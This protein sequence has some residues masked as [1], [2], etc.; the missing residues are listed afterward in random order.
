MTI[1]SRP[2][3]HLVL[4]RYPLLFNMED[5]QFWYERVDELAAQGLLAPDAVLNTLTQMIERDVLEGEPELLYLRKALHLHGTQENGARRLTQSA[6]LS[7]L[8][9]S[10]F[11]PPSTRCVGT[12]V[13][14]SLLY[15][16][17]YPFYKSIPEALTHDEL[18]RA[19]AWLVPERSRRIYDEGYDTRSRSPADFRRLLFQ[20][21]AGNGKPAVFNAEDARKQAERRAFDF[22]GADRPD[23]RRFAAINYDY[24]GDEMF[25]DVLDVLYATQPKDIGWRAPPR[26]AFRPIARELVGDRRVHFCHLS[27]PQDEFRAVARLIMTT[28]FGKPRV[29]IEQLADLDHVVDCITRPVIQR[30]DMGITWD[31]FDQ[32]AG[33]GMVSPMVLLSNAGHGTDWFSKCL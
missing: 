13:Y 18:V 28:Y 7:F 10:G 31:V 2:G 19:L 14:R 27:I 29:A 32:A 8:E 30:P 1:S 33:N 12:L 20:S 9:S 26:D 17:Q 25:H 21:F 4:F 15:L 22:T 16:S 23:S 5:S 6:F 11:L 24:D 3:H